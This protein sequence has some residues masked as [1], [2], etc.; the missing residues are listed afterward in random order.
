MGGVDEGGLDKPEAEDDAGTVENTAGNSWPTATA[1][2]HE[3]GVV[4]KDDDLTREE[5]LK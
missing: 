4:P 2:K 5:H 3:D 1:K